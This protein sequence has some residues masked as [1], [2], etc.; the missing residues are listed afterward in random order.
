MR[1]RRRTYGPQ[2]GPLLREVEYLPGRYRDEI[3][4]AAPRAI[5][6]GAKPPLAFVGIGMTGIV[7]ADRNRN[8]AYKVA[9]DDFSR[10]QIQEEAE[11]FRAAAKNPETRHLVPRGVRYHR[12]SGVLIRQYVDGKPGGEWGDDRDIYAQHSALFKAMIPYGW[13]APEKKSDSW[14]VSRKRGKKR[15]VLVDG[16]QAIRVGQVL[17]RHV[18]AV[19]R[20]TKPLPR[21]ET[22]SDL[23]Y[24]VY[25][26]RRTERYPEGTLALA[27]V[28][29]ALRALR[30][31]G[32]SFEWEV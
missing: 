3:L 31:A 17:L 32:A 15:A 11:W 29:R 27:D 22:L 4:E 30:A 5:A 24:A 6:A 7:F 26:E 19:A 23:A 8:L 28:R 2:K 13:T 18:L 9:R 10:S 16:G 25:R 14:V 21:G 1:R 20:G 12:P